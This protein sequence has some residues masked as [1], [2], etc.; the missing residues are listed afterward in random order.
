MQT[1]PEETSGRQQD[2]KYPLY[3]RALIC[4]AASG[5]LLNSINWSALITQ[6]TMLQLAM[7]AVLLAYIPIAYQISRR[8]VP[9]NAEQVRRWLSFTD[10]LLIGM[11]M[12]MSNFS[13]LPSLLFLTMVQF[14][15]LTQGGGRCWFE[16]NTAML[17][18]VGVGYLVHR[19]ALVVNADLN[20]SA[21]S[22][23]GV[24][25]YFCCYA[26]YTHKQIA[27]LKQDNQ[28]LQ[29]EQRIANLASYKLSR[30]LPKRLWRAVTTG[31]EKEI[32]TERKLL[33]VFF[34][35]IKDFSQLTEE[36]EAET[37]TRL[38]NTYLT[39]MSRIVAHYGG[40]IDKFI[41]DAVMVVFG[42][43]QSKGPKSDALRCVAM[44]LAM[45][46]RV[47]EMMQEWY[48]QGISHPLQIRM[49]INTG[50]CTVGV[51]GT[52]DH[53]TY[54]VMGTHVNLAARLESAA[55]PGEV[56]ISHETWA[57]IKQTVMCRDKGHVSVKGFS[58]PV[59]VYSVTDL[60]KN[61]GGQQSYL[62]EHAPGFAM[63]L[64]LEKVRNYD[65]EKVLQALQKAQA[66]L[67]SKVII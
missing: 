28:Q 65:K 1:Q 11:A 50:Y 18:G 29:K 49:G 3:F 63:H 59:K 38:L 60:R 7:A 57:M 14:N 35:D 22:L 55:D 67:K 15:A 58:T 8:S 54:T 30:Y 62:E 21:A 24:F 66:R 47:R 34:S 6:A 37:L 56:L 64:D 51:F 27:R 40:T 19:P 36:M 46:K 23:I 48:D 31:K 13:I 43:D 20:I 12:A 16:H 61:L 9:E 17:M 52:A 44:A 53:Q 45:R 26:F 4:F 39:E 32:V 42:D 33:T 2:S 5:T 41:G 10:A 25:T